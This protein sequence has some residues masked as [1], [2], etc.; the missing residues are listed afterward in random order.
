MDE[1]ENEF[2][3]FA[4]SKTLGSLTMARLD[5][6]VKEKGIKPDGRIKKADLVTA[7]EDYFKKHFDI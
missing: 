5:K 6:F 7:V 1:L 2:H 3:A 4:S